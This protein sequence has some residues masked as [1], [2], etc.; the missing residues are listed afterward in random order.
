MSNHDYRKIHKQVYKSK[1]EIESIEVP[2][3][4][5]LVS[6]GSSQRN[7]YEMHSGD[8]L[9]SFN[10]VANRLKDITKR[11]LNYKFT[12]MPLEIIWTKNQNDWSWVAMLQVPD[13]ISHHM[14]TEAILE[15][16]KRNRSIKVPVRLDKVH[17]GHCVQSLHIGPYHLVEETKDKIKNYCLEHGYQIN[18]VMREIYIN[19]PF[20][21]P[22]EK[23]R[24]II[25]AEIIK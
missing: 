14:F 4:Q 20:C 21:N 8:V 23:L 17:Q 15:L 19:Q 12:L 3:L 11:N 13:I 6:E 7:V 10:R 9:W 18:P 5:F 16:E 1:T 22:P 25:R 2:N 24:T